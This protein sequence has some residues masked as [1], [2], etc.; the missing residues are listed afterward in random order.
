VAKSRRK[1]SGFPVSPAKEVA[2]LD[3]RRL[4]ILRTAYA[5]IAR[6]GFEN[7]R[8]RD[9][10]NKA[11]INIATLHYY[12]PTKEDLI[13]GVALYLAAQ[14]ETTRAPAP[15]GSGA[16]QRLRQEFADG[17]FYLAK[18]PEMIEVMRELNARARRDAAIAKIIEPLKRYWCASIESIVADG[19][20]EG[21]FTT[22]LKPGE[23]AG[24]L[25]AM[26]WGAA[27][28]PLN[29]REREH[30][31]EAIESWLTAPQRARQEQ[32]KGTR[33]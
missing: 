8:T 20:A 22:A 24:A 30:V 15:G 10:A 3:A 14:F 16:L 12:F 32:E 29:A 28:L 2:G 4:S 13:A 33:R 21:V 1:S 7:L 17:R 23:A 6:D 18:R 26:L 19:I 9:V 11:G 25:V 27:T 31:Y 5:L